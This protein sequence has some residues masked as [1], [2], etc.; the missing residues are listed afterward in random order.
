MNTI[1]VTA[2]VIVVNVHHATDENKPEW[3][4]RYLRNLISRLIAKSKQ[5]TL[6]QHVEEDDVKTDMAMT[7]IFD[8]LSFNSC[9][10]HLYA[11]T[12]NNPMRTQ[13]C[14]NAQSGDT[15]DSLISVFIRHLHEQ[16]KRN[17]LERNDRERLAKFSASLDRL[18][19]WVFLGIIILVTVVMVTIVLVQRQL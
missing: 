2:S 16:D 5:A 9:N 18:F 12:E 4:I 1:N 19:L 8:T 14:E 15:I 7:E 3:N 11:E 10:R 6:N 17:T 13:T